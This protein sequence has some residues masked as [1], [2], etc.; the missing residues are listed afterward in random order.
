MKAQSTR[1]MA[2]PVFLALAKIPQLKQLT[3]H[4]E[5]AEREILFPDQSSS[6][7]AVKSLFTFIQLHRTGHPLEK[8]TIHSTSC[9]RIHDRARP[10]KSPT[11]TFHCRRTVNTDCQGQFDVDIQHGDASA[12]QAEVGSG[13]STRRRVIR[14]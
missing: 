9:T 8:L 7:M 6:I 1:L 13:F 11:I 3:I 5:M 4:T 12:A 14:L 10:Y 2:D